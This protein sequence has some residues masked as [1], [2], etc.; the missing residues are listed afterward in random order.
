M[1]TDNAQRSLL[2]IGKSQL[3]LNESVVGLRGLGY[4]A[5]ATNDFTDITGRFA[6]ITVRSTWSLW[7]DCYRQDSIA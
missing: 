1:T 2:L 7:S 3:V 6:P 5:E 4:K